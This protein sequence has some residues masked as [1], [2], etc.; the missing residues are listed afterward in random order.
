PECRRIA[1]NPYMSGVLGVPVWKNASLTAPAD[2]R[3]DNFRVYRDGKEIQPDQLPMQV[4]CTGVEVRDDEIDVVRS[5]GGTPKLL[6]HV[7]PLRDAAGRVRGSVGAFLDITSRRRMEEA[8]RQSEEQFRRAVLYAPF[9]ILIH[10]EGGEILQ[11]SRTWTELTGYTQEELPTISDWTRRAYGEK[12]GSVESDIERLYN[13]DA[14]VE[15]GEY[16][17][18]T[19][20]GETRTWD[21]HSAPL[22]RLPDGRRRVITMAVDVTER[23]RA[24]EELRRAK[25]AAEAANRAKDEFLAHGG[26]PI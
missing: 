25:E 3:P 7:R 11:V 20:S 14:R 4:A 17:I 15:E 23:K 6:C 26:H 1:H 12:R 21:F 19:R 8:L 16:I 18:T 2:E 24:E 10:A 22:G 9:P 5:D 13:L